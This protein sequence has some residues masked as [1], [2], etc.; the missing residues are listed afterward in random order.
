MG[1]QLVRSHSPVEIFGR[2]LEFL[3]VKEAVTT[4][5]SSR[6]ILEARINARP[7]I[8]LFL[9]NGDDHENVKECTACSEAI[10]ET[11]DFVSQGF[12][13]PLHAEFLVPA[14]ALGKASVL[15]ALRDLIPLR[16]L[17]EPRLRSTYIP[18]GCLEMAMPFRHDLVAL[19][20]VMG[21]GED[22][23]ALL[24]FCSRLCKEDAGGPSGIA[25]AFSAEYSEEVF[26]INDPQ[27]LFP[28]SVL[29][30]LSK[31]LPP[32]V[33]ALYL[34]DLWPGVL[35]AWSAIQLPRRILCFG[36][37][38]LLPEGWKFFCE[39]LCAQPDVQVLAVLLLNPIKSVWSRTGEVSARE[40]AHTI[41]K[42]FPNLRIL[43]MCVKYEVFDELA[44]RVHLAQPFALSFLTRFLHSLLVAIQGKSKAHLYSLKVN[45]RTLAHNS[46]LVKELAQLGF[47]LPRPSDWDFAPPASFRRP[48]CR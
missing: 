4:S 42:K 9:G 41:L 28:A 26:Q 23:K 7:S 8:A 21:K 29:V 30:S 40:V 27:Y 32:T 24:L 33:D 48:E 3:T 39:S 38:V 6:A 1:S 17:G 34:N 20:V 35:T 43:E 15:E 44:K 25:V 45:G 46:A 13:S 31:A 47:I 14:F 37:I 18:S 11:R 19:T 22:V 5:C 10:L 2:P 16:G 12:A 36:S